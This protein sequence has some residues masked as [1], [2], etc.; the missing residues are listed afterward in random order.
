MNK[1]ASETL[2][3]MSAHN[4]DVKRLLLES[5]QTSRKLAT[6]VVIHEEDSEDEGHDR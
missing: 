5:E 4:D 3:K 6:K 2:N 1:E